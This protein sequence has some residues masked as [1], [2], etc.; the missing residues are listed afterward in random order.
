MAPSSTS[1]HQSPWRTSVPKVSLLSKMEL[2]SKPVSPASVASIRLLHVVIRD[3]EKKKEYSEFRIA[4]LGKS[5]EDVTAEIERLHQV[6]SGAWP[7]FPAITNHAVAS[8]ATLSSFRDCARTIYSFCSRYDIELLR[9]R[10]P[11]PYGRYCVAACS[12]WRLCESIGV[13]RTCSNSYLHLQIV[14]LT[15]NR[16]SFI[17]SISGFVRNRLSS[18]SGAAGLTPLRSRTN[19]DTNGATSWWR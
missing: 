17:C 12:E 6:M 2:F 1:H 10:T 7:S 16:K 8:S 19:A 15:H 9:T 13:F 5:Q 4:R 14:A 18:S 11:C 3:S